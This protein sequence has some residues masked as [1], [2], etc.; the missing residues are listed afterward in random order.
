MA[1]GRGRVAHA[2]LITGPAGSGKGLFAEAL[3]CA[4]VCAQRGGAG[5]PCGECGPCRLVLAG[6]HPD[7]HWTPADG[8]L[9]IDEAREIGHA[10]S[11]A[12]HS[13]SCLIF[14]L[15]ACERLTDLAAGALLKTLEEPAGPTLFLLLTEH[16]EQIEPTLRSRCLTIRL[17]PVAPTALADWLRAAR[18]DLS[19][20]RCD[21]L[22]RRS[23]G[24]PGLALAAADA[25]A[26]GA[27]DADAAALRTASPAAAARAAIELAQ[28]GVAPEAALELLRDAWLRQRG[29]AEAVP[30]VSR[31]GAEALAA[32]AGGWSARTLAAAGQACLDAQEAAEMN[33]NAT[34]N[35]QVLLERLRRL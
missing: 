2:Q 23:R 26:D 8:K 18:P 27:A 35:W 3:A 12:A 7:L 22:A 31:A 25:P 1:L 10:A 9:G 6:E 24:L 20:E 21:A 30:P 14:V 17:R 19:P 28:R 29:W 13:A 5:Q 34:L 11:L 32:L 4:Q 16:P 15:E 33:V